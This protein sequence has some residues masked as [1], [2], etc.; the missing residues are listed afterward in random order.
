MLQSCPLAI[1]LLSD[2]AQLQLPQLFAEA[3]GPGRFT[4]AA[5]RVR[6]A[7]GGGA[8]VWFGATRAGVVIGALGMTPVLC[9]GLEGFLLGPVAV[10]N[11]DQRTL[12]GAKLIGHAATWAEASRS[13]FILLVGDPA[14]YGRFGFAPVPAGR[15]IFPGP[16]DEARIMAR[17]RPPTSPADLSGFV[18]GVASWSPP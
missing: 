14:Y 18:R 8:T 4:R 17:C 7:A 11:S 5:Y 1:A 16:V 13:R 6:E 15:V 12:I 2:S 3:F 10:R 9:G